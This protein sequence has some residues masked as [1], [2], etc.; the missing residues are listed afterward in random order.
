MLILTSDQLSKDPKM[1][2]PKVLVCI[3]L[4]SAFFLL[5]CLI[6]WAKHAKTIFAQS[7]TAPSNVKERRSPFQLYDRFSFFLCP[8]HLYQIKNQIYIRGHR[9]SWFHV[10]TSLQILSSF[11]TCSSEPMEP[12]CQNTLHSCQHTH[13]FDI[14]FTEVLSK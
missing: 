8:C 4:G 5:I 12:Y 7:A 2:A 11:H 1:Q 13:L 3:K 6:N 9:D 10:L 14:Y